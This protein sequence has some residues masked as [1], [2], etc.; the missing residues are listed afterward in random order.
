MHDSTVQIRNSLAK[1][2]MKSF[3]GWGNEGASGNNG[4]WFSAY[5]SSYRGVFSFQVSSVPTGVGRSAN[6]KVTGLKFMRHIYLF[7]LAFIMDIAIS[8]LIGPHTFGD[9]RKKRNRNQYQIESITLNPLS[10]NPK[11][12][13]GAHSPNRAI[14]NVEHGTQCAFL[15]LDFTQNRP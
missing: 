7:G 11:F 4:T 6:W 10:P 1:H 8:V 9:N 13:A 5:L 14:M 12:P 15:R 3:L 2:L